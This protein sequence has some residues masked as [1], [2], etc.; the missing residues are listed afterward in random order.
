MTA[1]PHSSLVLALALLLACS[2]PAAAESRT[3]GSIPVSKK[4]ESTEKPAVKEEAAKEE[5]KEK[6]PTKKAAKAIIVPS[7]KAKEPKEQTAE[8][9]AAKPA[10]PQPK[11]GKVNYSEVESVGLLRTA[12]EGSL[13]ENLWRGAKRSHLVELLRT[14]PSQEQSATMTA[15]KRRLL[16]TAASARGINNDVPASAGPDLMTL[17]LE[18]LMAMGLYREA[19]ELYAQI[20]D[21]PRDSALAQTG[22][23]AMLYAGQKSLA[24]LDA[25]AL[26]QKYAEETFWKELLAYC[27]ITLSATPAAQS[28]GV[29][30]ASDKKIFHEVASNNDARVLYN[31]K[32]FESLQPIEQAVLV[33]DKRLDAGNIFNA[34]AIPPR[35]LQLLLSNKNLSEKAQTLLTIQMVRHGMASPDALT[36]IYIAQSKPAAG[37]AEAEADD[38]SG[39]ERLAQL[40]AQADNAER[41][42][43]WPILQQALEMKR[44]F[45]AAALTPFASFIERVQPQKPSLGQIRAAFEVMHL[46]GRELPP[47]WIEALRGLVPAN[48]LIGSKAYH[49]FFIAVYAATPDFKRTPEDTAM[50]TEYLKQENQ[51]YSALVNIIIENLDKQGEDNDNAAEIYEKDYGLTRSDDYVMPS[52]DVW[53]RLKD[54]SQKKSLSETILLSA[55]ALQGNRAGKIY[56]GLL[57]DVLNGFETVGLTEFSRS[58]AVEALLENS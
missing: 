26:D 56:P 24:C 23:T 55:L 47:A 31:A 34:S 29:L 48:K 4:E 15:L 57:R 52:V 20:D 46:T 33:A 5:F 7:E 36:E 41:D 49:R 38:A 50:I 8:A 16:L 1:H 14:I 9:E 13:G 58:L 43:L 51:A 32:S 53:D 27:D 54:A 39:W 30:R 40:Y 25:R 42:A 21:A 18:K 6:K 22:V 37:K 19:F 44:Q 17:R 11:K 2:A 35:H 12:L 3:A 45:G 10:E 28:Y